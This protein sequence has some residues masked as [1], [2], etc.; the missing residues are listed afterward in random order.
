MSSAQLLKAAR[1]L[2]VDERLELID[3]LLESVHADSDFAL[4]PKQDAELERRHRA[5]LA[6]PDDG[7]TWEVVRER[8]QRKLDAGKARRPA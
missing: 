5:A 3:R 2:S 4:S 6:N 1:K 7:E 8:I